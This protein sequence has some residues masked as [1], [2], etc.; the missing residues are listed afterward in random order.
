MDLK[1]AGDQ[2]SKIDRLTRAG[3][4]FCLVMAGAVLVGTLAFN[5]FRDAGGFAVPL[6]SQLRSH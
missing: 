4:A 3:M 6:T 5:Q 1:T 2:N